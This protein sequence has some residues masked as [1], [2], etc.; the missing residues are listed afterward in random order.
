MAWS[1]DGSVLAVGD[2]DGILRW[3][4]V[5]AHSLVGQPVVAHTT[6]VT[7]ADYN[8]DGTLLASVSEDGTLR[9]WDAVT[10][11]TVGSPVRVPEGSTGRPAS[12]DWSPDDQRVALAMG[13][14]GV[15]VW[16]TLPEDA[17]CAMAK[18]SLGAERV[19]QILRTGP[20]RVITEPSHQ[21]SHWYEPDEPGVA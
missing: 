8:A 14:G 11:A 16:E 15:R 3:W 20:S 13:S 5:G 12:L 1:P 17:A 2:G 21:L 18:D 6:V 7:G 19:R 4:D 10:H 9:Y